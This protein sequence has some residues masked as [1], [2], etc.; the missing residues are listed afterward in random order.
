MSIEFAFGNWLFEFS[1]GIILMQII[2]NISFDETVGD[3]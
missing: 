3:F 1:V 2:I